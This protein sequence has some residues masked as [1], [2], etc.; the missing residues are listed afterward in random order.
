MSDANTTTIDFDKVDSTIQDWSTSIG[1][2]EPKKASEE[3]TL[4]ALQSAG[5]ESGFI[6]SYDKNFN[7][8]KEQITNLVNDIK[9]VIQEFKDADARVGDEKP[10]N[11][12]G[13]GDDPT[14][15]HSDEELLQLQLNEY[16][17]LSLENLNGIAEELIKLAEQEGVTLD[18]LLSNEKYK[19]KLQSIL[20]SSQYVPEDLKA[21]ILESDKVT[22]ELLKD[23]SSG[24]YPSVIGFDDNTK[25]VYYNYL[26]NIAN[27]NNITM[28]QL[29]TDDNYKDLLKKSF[30]V[31]SAVTAELV[32]LTDDQI[33]EKI[34]KVQ[35]GE[36]DGIDKD[37][38]EVLKE[39]ASEGDG[40]IDSVK[41]AGKFGVFGKM[42]E[43][44]SDD[45]S[46][47]AVSSLI[48]DYKPED[49]DVPPGDTDVPPTGDEDVPPSG[50]EDVPPGDTD[51]PPTGDEDVPP[52]DTDVPPS[53]DEDVP[54]GDTD[55]PPSGDEDVP[56]G[57]TDVP[58]TGDEDVPPSGD[59]DVP[60]GDT[61]VPPSGDEDVPP[62]DT[63]VPPTGDEDV[64][65][66]DTDVPP[67]GEDEIPQLDDFGDEDVP[68]E[69]TN[70]PTLD[71]GAPETEE[72]TLDQDQDVPM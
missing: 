15:Q 33:T 46:K 2:F 61:D 10:D 21:L 55:V 35:S 29:L 69:D 12:P 18:E 40:A 63:D 58:P 7:D 11:P 30:A 71:E 53:G 32:G 27:A 3:S 39:Y 50:D 4:M 38:A 8:A 44:S 49:E 22:Q 52:G 37:A 65:P 23:I 26:A 13:G 20:A 68:Q 57:D 31:F 47:S 42:S 67:T 14:T 1:S 45:S 34:K 25:K 9:T 6:A 36:L 64:P 51:V 62:G 48:Q 54:P 5:L 28:D 56:P 60:P 59:E 24:K 70:P 17:K 16:E 19:E 43:K 41:Q 72:P 66:G